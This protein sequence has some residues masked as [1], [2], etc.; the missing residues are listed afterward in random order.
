ML[1]CYGQ[2]DYISM[3]SDVNIADY[4][5]YYEEIGTYRKNG[6]TFK[7]YMIYRGTHTYNSKEMA[8][9]I[10]GLVQE[11]KQLDIETLEDKEIKE[12]IKYIEETEK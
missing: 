1:K 4:Y 10:D 12:L 2:R 6:N 8:I 9:F 5:N 11:A 3:L 7:S